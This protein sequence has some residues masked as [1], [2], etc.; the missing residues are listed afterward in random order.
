MCS[1]LGWSWRDLHHSISW[2]TLQKVML[3][4]ARVVYEDEDKKRVQFTEQ[5]AGEM[6]KAINNIP[7]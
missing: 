1:H 7:R 6:F 3:D 4:Q 2:V 5:S